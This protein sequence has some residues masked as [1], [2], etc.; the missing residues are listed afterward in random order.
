MGILATIAQLQKLKH[1][2]YTT[3]GKVSD[4]YDIQLQIELLRASKADTLDYQLKKSSIEELLNQGASSKVFVNHLKSCIST[5]DYSLLPSG[6]NEE[7]SI[8][9][10]KLTMA[11]GFKVIGT[12]LCEK[13]HYSEAEMKEKAYQDALNKLKTLEEYS[14]MSKLNHINK[15]L[16]ALN[17]VVE[18]LEETLISIV[19]GKSSRMRFTF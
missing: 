2:A 13:D 10:C 6:V 7:N 14:L 11:N 17:G 9:I 18:L 4:N 16:N 1:M 15:K 3:T 19:Q 8:G 5:T 12:F